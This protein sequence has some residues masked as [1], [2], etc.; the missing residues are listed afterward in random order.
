MHLIG[1]FTL[2]TTTWD[3]IKDRWS[4]INRTMQPCYAITSSHLGPLWDRKRLQVR[5]SARM[6]RPPSAASARLDL[7]VRTLLQLC[8]V[9]EEVASFLKHIETKEET[10]CVFFTGYCCLCFC[11]TGWMAITADFL[12]STEPGP[13]EAALTLRYPEGREGSCQ[14]SHLSLLPWGVLLQL[15][16]HGA[17]AAH[18]C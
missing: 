18:S 5:S 11:P 12:S 17:L 1:I 2:A 9:G 4:Y 10:G 14:N 7:I 15:L 3:Y 16:P 8:S 6:W 13:A